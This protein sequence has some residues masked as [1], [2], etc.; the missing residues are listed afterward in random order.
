MRVLLDATAIPADRGGVG[1]YLDGLIPALAARARSNSAPDLHLTVACQGRDAELY[2]RTGAAVLVAPGR[3]AGR[4][5]RLAWEQTGLPRMVRAHSIDVV[6]SPHYTMPVLAGVPTVVTLHDATF[7]SDP[8]L[9][10]AVKRRFFTT[11]TRVALRRAA[12]IIVPSRAT[13]DELVRLVSKSASRANVAH[14][15]VDRDTFH[16]P[17][18]P[19]VAELRA[20]LGLGEQPF[21]AFLGTIEP[22]KNVS[23]LIRGWVRAANAISSR[24]AKPALVL[25]GGPGWD[26]TVAAAISEVPPELQLIRP[27]Y[28]ELNR[29]R[30]LLGGASV[31]VYPALGEGFGLPVLEAM[32]CGAATLTTRRLA[33]PE[34]GGD[35]VEY[36]EVDAA[37]IAAALG[38]LLAEPSRRAELAARALVRSAEFTWEHAAAIHADVYQ[39]AA[40]GQE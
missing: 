1:R 38:Q 9:H 25:A 21:I 27:G 5:Q 40:G 16:P 32:A 37:S 20:A 18:L 39:R 3:I 10:T 11:A 35:A 8:V 7:F 26:D 13:R 12:E 17:A 33:L 31:V 34:V 2:R 29:L 19:E 22:R 6:H 24:Q 15:G 4:A 28:L 36:T 23:N 30:A 14:H